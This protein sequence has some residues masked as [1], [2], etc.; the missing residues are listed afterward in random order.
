MTVENDGRV[1]DIDDLETLLTFSTSIKY[2][3]LLLSK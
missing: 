2:I 3:L 1:K